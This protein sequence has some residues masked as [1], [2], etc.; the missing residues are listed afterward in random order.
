M[1]GV[2]APVDVP[3]FR[4]LPNGDNL[5]RIPLGSARV[6]GATSGTG[7]RPDQVIPV[8]QTSEVERSGQGIGAARRVRT[9]SGSS[10][11]CLADAAS[12]L[13]SSTLTSASAACLSRVWIIP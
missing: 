4:S 9:D 1:L 13:T 12:L 11:E 8:F 10:H 6:P 2:Q 7:P 5:S 3:L